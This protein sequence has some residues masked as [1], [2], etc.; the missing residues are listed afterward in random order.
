MKINTDFQ[1]IYGFQ[2]GFEI[3]PQDQL[4][5]VGLTFGVSFDF[6]IFRIVFSA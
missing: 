1:F 3:A 5:E 6:G 2:F 4:E